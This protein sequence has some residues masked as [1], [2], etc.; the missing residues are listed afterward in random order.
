MPSGEIAQIFAA[1]DGYRFARLRTRR[2]QAADALAS[3][4]R[5]AA[6]IREALAPR[7]ISA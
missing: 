5:A 3:A 1:C 4:R 7:E 6:A 2:D